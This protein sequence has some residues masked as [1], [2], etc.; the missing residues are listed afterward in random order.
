M[1]LFGRRSKHRVD[2]E[3]EE[4]LVASRRSRGESG[5][6]R[7]LAWSASPE[8][9]AILQPHVLS[10][11]MAPDRRVGDHADDE[12]WE[13]VGWHL[14]EKGGWNS[15]TATLQWSCYGGR[16][17]SITLDQP[18]RVPEVFRERVAATIAV[19][20]F[21]PLPNSRGGVTISGRRDLADPDNTIT[22]HPTLSKSVNRHTPGL[23]GLIAELIAD[24][25]AEYDN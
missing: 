13:H 2:P 9:V 8:G 24:M 16:R 17:G 3:I 25:K 4:S 6:P 20:Q 11:W 7:I 1:A 5:K 22:W 18:G 14:V 10:V 23:E 19:Q 15:E 21:Q 12:G